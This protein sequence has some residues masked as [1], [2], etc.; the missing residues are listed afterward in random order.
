MHQ[1]VEITWNF[2]GESYKR[3]CVNNGSIVIGGDWNVVLNP[4]ID[5]NHLINIYCARSQK[6][7]VDFMYTW[8]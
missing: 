4:K 3:S 1:T 2:F 6:Q 8:G 7:I 5:S